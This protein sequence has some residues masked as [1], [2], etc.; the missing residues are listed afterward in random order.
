ML[1]ARAR[2]LADLEANA[3]LVTALEL[4]HARLVA[5]SESSNADDEHDPEG[6]T[7]A[8]ERE[9]LTSSLERARSV[10]GDLLHALRGLEAGTFGVC[11]NCRR[12]I[13][14]ERLAA[15]PHARLC[16]DCARAAV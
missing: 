4:D 6:A 8:F 10:R 7:I 9:Q 2:L 1:D 12:P 5:A 3:S 16:I 14:A 13:G 11:E 15:R